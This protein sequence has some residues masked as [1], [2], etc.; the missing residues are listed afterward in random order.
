MAANLAHPLGPFLTEGVWHLLQNICV[1]P[2]RL[3]S[4]HPK[5]SGNPVL[6]LALRH[7]TRTQILNDP[8]SITRLSATAILSIGGQ[9]ISNLLSVEASSPCLREPQRSVQHRV[10]AAWSAPLRTLAPWK[11]LR[12]SARIHC[13]QCRAVAQPHLCQR[14]RVGRVA[15]VWVS[16]LQLT[17]NA[18]RLPRRYVLLISL[19]LLAF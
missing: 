15:G 13:S 18:R 11:I 2:A 8:I 4:W 6:K 19:L 7:G 17:A 12:T 9:T 3:Q 16:M 14:S 5:G 1:L 10:S